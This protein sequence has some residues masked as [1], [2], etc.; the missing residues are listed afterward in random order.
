[1]EQQKKSERLM[2]LDALRGFDMLFISGLAGVICSLCAVCG[3]P[4]CALVQ[5]FEHVPWAGFHFEDLIFPL[6]L[7]L[8]GVSFP[9]S[10]SKQI[11]A[12]R[13]SWQI[14]RKIILR[15]AIL[16]L[17][18]MLMGG[19]LKGYPNFRIPSVLGRI[20]VAWALAA[21]IRVHVKKVLPRAL[22][23]VALLFGYWAV[24][25]AFPAPDYTGTDPF[26]KAGCIICYLDRTLMTNH[27]LVPGVYDPESIF[28]TFPAIVT[29][30][31]GIFAGELL[32][33]PNLSGAKKSLTLALSAALLLAAG[34]AFTFLMP[35]IKALWSSSFTLLAAGFSAALLALFYYIIDV[36]GFKRWTLP[37]RVVGM[38]AITIY[39]AQAY[40]GFQNVTNLF[41][42]W[43][44]PLLGEA[45]GDLFWNLGYLSIAWL[46]L[47]FL[48]R[49][50][51]FLK[52]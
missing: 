22:I 2:S 25:A 21:L 41:F 3:F 19:V 15:G 23:C 13:T 44:K 30:L 7:F 46:F 32:R 20:G 18:G 35:S 9:F 34:Y 31:L 11:A 12:G 8:A 39:L 29:A 40:V 38:N 5:Q 43:T 33:N 47:Y 14:H 27:I 16:F 52:V 36:L 17:L 48:Y 42:G 6:F 26:S 28:S 10:L 51:I 24:L 37:L 49:K 1:M 4:N 50:N 45:W